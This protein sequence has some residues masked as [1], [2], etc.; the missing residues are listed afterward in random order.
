MLHI[1][2]QK[3]LKKN[4]RLFW[5]LPFK[6]KFIF[7]LFCF[8]ILYWFCHTLTWIRHRCT[9]APNP[10]YPSHLPSHIISLDHPHAPAPSIPYPVSNIDWQFA[11]YM[12][13]YMFQCRIQDAWGW[14]MG[15]IQR[16][17]MRWEVGG[18]RGVHVWELMY[19]CGKFMS[20]YG[21]TNTV[22]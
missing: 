12:I 20:M 11:S 14:C 7:T 3:I 2:H 21:K 22:L 13:V 10:E 18:W 4:E 16:D 19:T 15:K 1:Y 5:V 8:I 6:K 17:D 9:Q